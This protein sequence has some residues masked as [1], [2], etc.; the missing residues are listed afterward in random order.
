MLCESWAP[1]SRL[2]PSRLLHVYCAP[3]HIFNVC[4]IVLCGSECVWVCVCVVLCSNCRIVFMMTNIRQLLAM[5]PECFW[6]ATPPLIEA[7]GAR[8][9]FVFLYIRR[10][11]QQGRR[12]LLRIQRI[13]FQQWAIYFCALCIFCSIAERANAADCA[14][15]VRTPNPMYVYM[16]EEPFKIN[17]DQ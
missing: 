2:A 7:S 16:I 10:D 11:S 1:P 13:F 9:F 5:R 3:K 12:A 8:V 14:A 6:C 15:D 17:L 4:A